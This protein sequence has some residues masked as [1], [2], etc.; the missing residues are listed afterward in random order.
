MML[1]DLADLLYQIL[2][3][4]L[5]L[6]LFAQEV[7]VVRSLKIINASSST[8]IQYS[9]EIKVFMM[10]SSTSSTSDLLTKDVFAI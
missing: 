6:T 7:Q 2:S 3:S 10:F 9:S 5:M 8:R 4:F 1:N